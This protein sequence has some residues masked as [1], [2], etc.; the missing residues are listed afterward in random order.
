MDYDIM[1]FHP[2]SLNCIITVDPETGRYVARSIEYPRTLGSGNNFYAA[3]SDLE[4]NIIK[5]KAKLLI[6][7]EEAIELGKKA[8]PLVKH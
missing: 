7:T 6:F 8:T 3:V 5:L 1:L 2:I 4:Q